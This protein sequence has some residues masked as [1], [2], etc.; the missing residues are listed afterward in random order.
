M[1]LDSGS[2][3]T[4]IHKDV[5]PEG[6]AIVKLAKSK[7]CNTLSGSFQ[8]KEMVRLRDRRLPKLYK[9]RC[10]DKQRALLFEG[11]CQYGVILGSDFLEKT[12]INLLYKKK[13][14]DWFGVT[15]PMRHA[16]E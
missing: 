13:V 2:M 15:V 6:A 5:V 12:G 10:I 1:L 7:Q 3:K 16:N 8:V 14:T 11:S 4:L 9:N